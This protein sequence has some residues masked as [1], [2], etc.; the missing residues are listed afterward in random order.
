MRSVTLRTVMMELTLVSVSVTLS[1]VKATLRA[2][3][4]KLK[5][6]FSRRVS[7]LTKFGQCVILILLYRH[8]N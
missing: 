1:N 5:A 8:V 4:T 7:Y 3:K 2:E 6:V